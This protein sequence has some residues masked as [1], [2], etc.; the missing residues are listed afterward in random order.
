MKKSLAAILILFC[1]ELGA[2]VH[3]D[4]KVIYVSGEITGDFPKFRELA[5]DPQV[6][7]VVFRDSSGG[8]IADGLIMN[9]IIADKRLKTSYFGFCHSSCALAFMGGS[10][11]NQVKRVWGVNTL[12]FHAGRLPPSV[13]YSPQP[14]E[15]SL[16]AINKYITDL[17]WKQ[18]TYR[19]PKAVIDQIREADTEHGGV[20]FRT[21]V[22]PFS[23]NTEV[24]HCGAQRRDPDDFKTCTRID[25]AN[26]IRYGILTE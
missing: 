8:S 10:S 3:Q 7:E 26:L 19:I 18:S 20:F 22:T 1:T 12:S 14:G 13:A 11:R 15:P 2:A 16:T 9:K 17:I 21:L 23:T 6:T 24:F 25:G 5:L 4:G